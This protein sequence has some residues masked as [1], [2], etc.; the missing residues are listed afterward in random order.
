MDDFFTPPALA[1]I[2][3]E[4]PSLDRRMKP[5]LVRDLGHDGQSVFFEHARRQ[6]QAVWIHDPSRTLRLFREQL[7]SDAMV[8][9]FDR[10]REPL[11][12]IIPSCWAPHLQ[13][14]RYMT[15][16]HY[17]F[18]E[19]E[20][21]GVNLTAIVFLAAEPKKVRG[22]DLVLAYDGDETT[23]R[24]RHN[25]LVIFPSRTLHRVTR[26]RV[27]G[28]DPRHARVSLQAWLTYGRPPAKPKRRP[29]EADR[30]TF[31]LAEEPILAAAQAMSA[32]GAGDQTPEDLYWGAFYLSR[33]LTSNLR[34]LIAEQADL[35]IGQIRIRRRGELEVY[36]RGRLGG[37]P[38]RV[39]FVL[40]GPQTA[41][42]EA[43][44]LFVESGRGATASTSRRT[45]PPGA[46]ERQT[47][48]LLRRLLARVPRPRA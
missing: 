8:A 15:G 31:L 5:G 20:G 16:D 30:P 35:A 22:G 1:A 21:A 25:R 27:D 7:W 34:C 3:R 37:A 42:A 26:V 11:F 46:G 40:R 43:L 41:P 23:V 48:A 24:F 6:N 44:S 29:P 47:A 2:F 18:H 32:P 13:V 36:G 45:V 12:Q 9:S 4:L 14:S 17:D 38:V 28:T 33:I 39:G 19:D 10:A